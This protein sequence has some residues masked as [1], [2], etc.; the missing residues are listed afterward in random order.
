MAVN[1]DWWYRMQTTTPLIEYDM[2]KGWQSNKAINDPK[3]V[4][5]TL[6]SIDKALTDL[7]KI[8]F[9]LDAA[10]SEIRSLSGRIFDAS[11]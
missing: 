2:D 1:E 9:A 7:R 3:S 10:K 5:D 8:R 11:E 4:D 6:R